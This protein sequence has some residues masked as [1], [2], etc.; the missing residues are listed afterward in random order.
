[1]GVNR[2][3]PPTEHHALSMTV[4]EDEIE[5]QGL[6]IEWRYL[7]KESQ[8]LRLGSA[9]RR[10]VAQARQAKSALGVVQFDQCAAELL[11]A[12]SDLVLLSDTDGRITFVNSA[13][14]RLLGKLGPQL[15]GQS[16]LSLYTPHGR[17]RM[18]A[19]QCR[20][21]RRQSQ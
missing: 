8:V 12:S 21:I 1:M 19:E 13:G 7:T 14:C 20:S 3:I 9:V 16:W 6:A 11:E 4:A 10:S 2:R 18:R 15:L 5:H 17:K